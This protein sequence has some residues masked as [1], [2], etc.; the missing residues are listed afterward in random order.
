MPAGLLLGIGLLGIFAAIVLV[1]AT[2][3]VFTPEQTGASRSLAAIKA[4]RAAPSSLRAETERGFGERLIEPAVR[5]LSGLGRRLTPPG[6]LDK[7]RKRLDLAGNPAGWTLERVLAA[8]LLGGLVLPVVAILLA[9]AAGLSPLGVVVAAIAG[10]AVG[11][12]APDMALSELGSK[13]TERIQHDLPDALDLLTVSV[14]AGLGFDA[15]LTQVARNTEGPLA[16]EFFRV[17]QEVQLGMSREEALRAFAE[18]TDLEELKGFVAAVVQADAF[19]VP[20]ANVLRV[21]SGEIRVKRRQRAEEQAQKVPVK[22][23]FPL[24]FC[25]M[26]SLFIVVLGPAVIQIYHGL[27]QHG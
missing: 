8:K 3:G 26:P 23:L 10:A 25:I 2:V 20:I 15:A 21:Q 19:G 6:R 18:C 12:F 27:I 1:L 22:I 4:W 24:I 11:Y 14:E 13:R 16:E 7:I 5:R 17:L 9:V